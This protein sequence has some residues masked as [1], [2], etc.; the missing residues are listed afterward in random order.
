LNNSLLKH[1]ITTACA[2]MNVDSK[3]YYKQLKQTDVVADDL[4]HIA[5]SKLRQIKADVREYVDRLICPSV[6]LETEMESSVFTSAFTSCIGYVKSRLPE[7]S[8]ALDS[9]TEPLDPMYSPTFAFDEEEIAKTIL[10]WAD[11]RGNVYFEKGPTELAE[12]IND[13]R[14]WFS[15]NQLDGKSDVPGDFLTKMKDLLNHETRNSDDGEPLTT[16]DIALMGGLHPRTCAIAVKDLEKLNI[17]VNKNTTI[18]YMEPFFEK[19]M[20][21]FQ[22]RGDEGEDLGYVISRT[23]IGQRIRH[24][25]YL[26]FLRPPQSEPSKEVQFGEP[27]PAK[28]ARD[29]P[30]PREAPPEY[31]AR[32]FKNRS[33]ETFA[34]YCDDCFAR[35]AELYYRLVHTM[36]IKDLKEK[37]DREKAQP[38]VPAYIKPFA[39]LL[40]LLIKRNEINYPRVGVTNTAS[41][42]EARRV[43]ARAVVNAKIALAETL[44]FGPDVDLEGYTLDGQYLAGI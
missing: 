1:L 29:A 12:F 40:G 28:R 9:L 4:T 18:E 5:D 42:R 19:C 25:S 17:V 21:Y 35:G 20:A 8:K 23:P 10:Q 34:Q 44:G 11:L 13:P 33:Q 43:N 30:A 22:S 3:Q 15:E 7:S 14:R 38:S 24:T 32:F 6:F 26:R 39:T 2:T 41:I 31:D 37:R 36:I 27:P 16:F